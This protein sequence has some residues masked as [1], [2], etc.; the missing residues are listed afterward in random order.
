MHKIYL[1]SQ[2]ISDL[3]TSYKWRNDSSIWSKTVGEGKFK[4]KKITLKD[5]IE[6]FKKITKKKNRKNIS[7]FLENNKLVGNIYFTNIK[8]KTAQFQIVI[9]NKNYWN[10]GI[11]YR[12]TKL[13]LTFA[14]VNYDINKFYLFV[15]K[16]NKYAILIYK[17]I[18]FKI[19]QSVSSDVLKMHYKFN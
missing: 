10:K 19:S 1:K 11:G 9:G 8:N 16:T 3:R 15:K 4:L 2:H 18:G 7:I 6:W 5:E 12:S 13:S 17:K 14:N